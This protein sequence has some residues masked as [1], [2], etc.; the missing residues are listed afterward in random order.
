ML[1]A[2][3]A[4]KKANL[5]G[6]WELDVKYIDWHSED[7]QTWLVG[8]PGRPYRIFNAVDESTVQK[9]W[10]DATLELWFRDNASDL[11]LFGFVR[12]ETEI[13]TPQIERIWPVATCA[14]AGLAL[15]LLWDRVDSD[16]ALGR[17]GVLRDV[18]LEVSGM[19]EFPDTKRPKT[20]TTTWWYRAWRQIGQAAVEMRRKDHPAASLLPP[21]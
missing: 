14:R 8:C 12:T 19:P 21:F 7:G 1:L 20:Y 5:S 9:L 18:L 15:R 11:E 3:E 16:D 17:W 6:Q 2:T 13:P 10:E 4:A